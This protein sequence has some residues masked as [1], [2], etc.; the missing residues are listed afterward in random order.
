[1]MSAA[2]PGKGPGGEHTPGTM[3]RSPPIWPELAHGHRLRDAR[4]HPRARVVSQF[5]PQT[6]GTRPSRFGALRSKQFRRWWTGWVISISSLLLFGGFIGIIIDVAGN[7]YV[8][9]TDHVHAEMY[10]LTGQAPVAAPPSSRTREHASNETFEEWA[11]RQEL[12]ELPEQ[13]EQVR[14]E[15]EVRP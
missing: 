11:A 9:D 10:S 15:I 13:Q 6:E 12:P 3:P 2:L 1:M 8:H 7:G 5:T 4:R 14:P